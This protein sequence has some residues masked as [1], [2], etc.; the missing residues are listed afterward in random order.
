[1]SDKTKRPCLDCILVGPRCSHPIWLID[2]TIEEENNPKITLATDY[3]ENCLV[4]RVL[5]TFRF[6]RLS[7]EAL[8]RYIRKSIVLKA[9]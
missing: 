7:R 9:Q 4:R 6:L 1:V 8:Y 5:M 2:F 3:L